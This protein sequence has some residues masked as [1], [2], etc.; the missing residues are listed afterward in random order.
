MTRGLTSYVAQ[1]KYSHRQIYRLTDRFKLSDTYTF[2][3]FVN[4][5]VCAFLPFNVLTHRSYWW[6]VTHRYPHALEL[7]DTHIHTHTHT[8]THTHTHTLTHTHIHTH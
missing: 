8:D 4:V 5:C 2:R 1:D 3:Y 7:A 6:D